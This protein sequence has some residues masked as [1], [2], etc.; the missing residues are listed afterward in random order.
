MECKNKEV[1][2]LKQEFDELVSNM[3]QPATNNERID[4]IEMLIL[5]TLLNIGRRL[6]KCYIEH[7]KEMAEQDMK[8]KSDCRNQDKGLFT[9]PYFS[10]FGSIR[11][12]RK[13]FYMTEDKKIFYPADRAMSMPKEEYSYNLQNWIGH[14]ATDTDFRSSVELIN[15]IFEYNIKEM[16]AERI[17]NKLSEEVEV[18]YNEQENIPAEKEGVFF[19]G[20]FDD[21][22]V[23]IL[24]ADA[25]RKVDS[26]GVRLGKGQKRG[27]KKSCTVSVTYSFNPNVRTAEDVVASL[28]KE[29]TNTETENNNPCEPS[30]THAKNKHIR[31]FLSD[32][33]KAMEYGLDNLPKRS[34]NKDKNIVILI[35]GDRGLEKAID[36]AIEAK[37]IQDRVIFKVLDFIHV[38]EYLWKAA[39]IYYGEKSLQRITWVREHSLLLLQG[40]TDDVLKDLHELIKHG[41]YQT[42][43]HRM[44]KKVIK[45]LSNHKHMMNYKECLARGFPIS[46]GAIESACG[47]FVQSRMERNGMRW[48]IK[49][50][51]NILNLRSVRKNKDWEN[52]MKYYIQKKEESIDFLNYRMVA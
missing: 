19:A 17:S 26:N 40:K 38:V 27:T 8:R 5:R 34:T 50:A 13:K 43:K 20:G 29:T 35:D 6:L 48:S 52:Y 23:P 10:I 30:G 47:H 25:N 36:K 18:F 2:E 16:Q 51:K 31:A 32:K 22:G 12:S 21:K 15:Q 1:Q 9:R 37:G 11:F 39:N 24:P 49:G 7:I 3:F 4:K 33:Q 14:S 46:T 42:A 28:F 45:Y 41:K 44:I